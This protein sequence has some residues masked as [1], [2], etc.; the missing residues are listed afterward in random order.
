MDISYVRQLLAE[1]SLLKGHLL[2]LLVLLVG[3]AACGGGQS[4]TGQTATPQAGSKDLTT[5]INPCSLLTQSQVEGVL[6][7]SLSVTQ[8]Q[9]DAH[10]NYLQEN[11]CTYVNRAHETSVVIFL[12]T[13]SDVATAGADFHKFAT[14]TGSDFHSLAH[15]GEQALLVARPL[16]QLFVQQDNGILVVGIAS[17]AGSAVREQQEQQLAQMAVQQM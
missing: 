3:C 14:L 16:P 13:F 7:T 10:G 11:P 8:P 9:P 17:N 12:A 15:L 6:K 5:Q 2:A 1:T 4:T